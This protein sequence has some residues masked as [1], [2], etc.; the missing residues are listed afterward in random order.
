LQTD[1]EDEWMHGEPNEAERERAAIG[2]RAGKRGR[3]RRQRHGEQEHQSHAAGDEPRRRGDRRL[4]CRIQRLR[5]IGTSSQRAVTHEV[6]E[7]VAVLRQDR[8]VE[9]RLMERRLLFSVRR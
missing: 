8:A 2:G 7:E 5:P 6:P 9:T 1:P 4:D 3:D